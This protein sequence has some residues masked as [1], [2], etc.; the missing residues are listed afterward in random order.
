MADTVRYLMEE[1]VPELEE[2]EAKG[3][4]SRKEVKAIVQRRQ[5]FEY[6]LKRRAA[7]KQDFYRYIE[8]ETKLEELRQL[9]KKKLG[10]KGEAPG[11]S[12]LIS[13][14][15]RR[16]GPPACEAQGADQ[17]PAG[18]LGLGLPSPSWRLA[19]KCP[20]PCS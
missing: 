12:C 11:S 15:N 17:R 20:C 9:R 8:Y 1:M 16:A 2:L 7:L 14:R 19:A 3:Y 4:F 18:G 5:D 6:L 10:I 13:S